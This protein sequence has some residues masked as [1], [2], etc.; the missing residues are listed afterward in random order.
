M[1]YRPFQ[2]LVAIE[3]RYKQLRSMEWKNLTDNHVF[4]L[5]VHNFEELSTSP[6]HPFRLLSG[7]V[8]KLLCVPLFDITIERGMRYR[9][10]FMTAN[11]ERMS[12]SLVDSSLLCSDGL[13]RASSTSATLEFPVRWLAGN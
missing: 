3:D 6:E 4:W 10:N 9:K 2:E 12:D 1:F 5:G 8:L 11:R 13:A 7:G